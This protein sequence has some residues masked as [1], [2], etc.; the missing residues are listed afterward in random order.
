VPNSSKQF[1]LNWAAYGS[2]KSVPSSTK[3]SPQ[4]IQIYIG[5]IDPSVTEHKL[6]EFFK[7]KY[8]SAYMS[9]IITDTTTKVSKG[10]GFVKFT[11][12]EE[13]AK[14]ITE[15]NGIHLMG[16]SIKVSTAYLKTKEETLNE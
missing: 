14:A 4:E 5:D 12:H 15:M 10:Y 1:K 9:K 7:S 13:S 6:L 11:N 8:P 3:S 16:K 2:S